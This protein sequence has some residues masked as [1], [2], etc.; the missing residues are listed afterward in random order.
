MSF[1]PTPEQEQAMT[2]IDRDLTVCAGAGSGKTRVLVERY[3]YLLEQGFSFDQILAVT[4]TR[5]AAQEMKE[6]IRQVLTNSDTHKHLLLDLIHAQIS[7]IHS[8]CQRIVA[9]HPREAQVDPRFRMAEEWESKGILK[10]VVSDQVSLALS[11]GCQQICD[12][13]EEFRQSKELVGHLV[14]VYEQMRSKG[15]RQFEVRNESQRL[16]A[17]II[18]L[19]QELVIQLDAWIMEQSGSSLSAFAQKG[20]DSVSEVWALV[21][22]DFIDLDTQDKVSIIEQLQQGFKGQRGKFKQTFSQV[23]DVL[24]QLAQALIDL[25]GNRQLVAIGGLLDQIHQ[26]YQNCKIAMGLLDF[27]DLEE[28]AVKLLSMPQVRKNYQYAHI[29]LDE[30]QDTNSMQKKIF[31]LLWSDDTKLFVVGDPKQ[32]IYRFRGAEVDVFLQAQKEII[33]R[34]GRHIALQDNFRSRPGIIRFANQFFQALMEND[35]IGYEESKP[36]REDLG[37]AGVDLLITE[38]V[39]RANDNR[40]EEARQI[41][42]YIAKLVNEG[43][44]YSE[45]TLLFR[46]MSSVKVYEQALQH[47]AIPFVNLSGRGFYEKQEIID[48]LNFISW[49]QD[50]KDKVNQIAV[51]RSPFFGI[52]DQGLFWYQ[53]GNI[54]NMDVGD[55]K[56]IAEAHQIYPKLQQSLVLDGAPQFLER[57]VTATLFLETIKALP[58]GDQQWANVQKLLQTSWQLWAKGYVSISDQ[59][60]YIEEILE[61]KGKEG[62]ARLD[63]EDADV[64]TIMTI[65]GSKGLE[66]PYVILPD[67]NRELSPKNPGYFSYHP[68]YGLAVRDTTNYKQVKAALA[69][70]E[71]QE[72]KRLFYVAVTR[73]QEHL[74]LSGIGLKEQMSK[75]TSVDQMN[76]WWD[77][78]LW[79]MDR[80][81]DGLI[82]HVRLDLAPHVVGSSQLESPVIDQKVELASPIPVSYGDSSFSVTS[83]MVYAQCPRRYYYRYILRVPEGLS[84]S[85]VKKTKFQDLSPLQRGN[86]VHRVCEQLDPSRVVDALLEWAFSMEGV[87]VNENDKASLMPIIS[88]YI[89]SPYYQEIQGGQ[90]ER[91][92]EFSLP[93]AEF[94]ITGTVDQLFYHQEGLVIM[95]L[96][97]N[98]INSD[99]LV[100][101]AHQYDW[102]MRIYAW[103]MNRRTN[104][105]IIK[106]QL[107]FLIP[108]AIYTHPDAHNTLK[109]TEQW[110]LTTCR[111]I[112]VAESQ[113]IQGFPLAEPCHHCGY[114]CNQLG[115]AQHILADLL[116]GLGTLEPK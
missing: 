105:A 9:T 10:Q 54:D 90:V 83:L 116:A 50:S 92:V 95:D 52:S 69:Q 79:G 94:I 66:F 56:K 115:N 18:P 34:E 29:V 58:M 78:V 63:A 71:L 30:S 41:V 100:D 26:E 98:N 44:A 99:Q 15:E 37:R 76:K 55:Q 65:H 53:Q 61:Q 21:Q 28:L 101:E 38:S 82:N 4:F 109:Q 103:A 24:E 17:E 102:Q 60:H 112:Q 96:K 113:G 85:G 114:G 57:L 46:S 74:T 11:Q 7:T 51:L 47:Q 86:I 5:K 23:S 107:Y 25:L 22:D 49:L 104:L 43:V 35:P 89:H 68:E 73:A 8:L 75:A 110:L 1:S 3:I 67:L 13:R 88:A 106:T 48:V 19:Q 36:K 108:N 45:I 40:R 14:D 2:M 87:S 81:E 20:F 64:V 91:E 62:E 93:L 80:I 16:W 12:L 39:G 111:Q 42:G 70:D 97:T 72:A 27:N 6:R 59:L 33:A 77:W 32:S 31:D 84:S